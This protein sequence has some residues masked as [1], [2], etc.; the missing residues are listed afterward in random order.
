MVRPEDF[1]GIFAIIL[2]LCIPIVAI[3]CVFITSIKNKRRETELRKAIIQNHVDSESIKL[4]VEAPKKKSDK[5][6]TL[7]NGCLLVGIG[8]GTLANYLLGLAPKHDITYWLV[9][10][11]GMG[12]GLLAAF[13]IEYRLSAREKACQSSDG[14]ETSSAM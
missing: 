5:Y 3:V 10:A 1:E 6:S 4:L 2:S 12:I 11:C 9:I 14:Q 8:L 7:R 13:V